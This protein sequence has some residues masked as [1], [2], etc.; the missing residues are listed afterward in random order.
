MAGQKRAIVAVS[1]SVVVIT[2]GTGCRLNG[3]T[4]GCSSGGVS[5]ERTTFD[6]MT[7]DVG[8]HLSPSS[9]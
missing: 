2:P 8:R 5:P 4:A 7:R 6:Q 3:F 1:R 9:R